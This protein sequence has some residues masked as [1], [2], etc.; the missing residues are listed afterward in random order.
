MPLRLRLRVRKIMPLLWLQLHEREMW[1]RLRIGHNL[2]FR[3]CT[4]QQKNTMK[5][6]ITRK[7]HS[8][9][10]DP[11]LSKLLQR[12]VNNMNKCCSVTIMQFRVMW[13]NLHKEKKNIKYGLLLTIWYYFLI[14]CEVYTVTHITQYKSGTVISKVGKHCEL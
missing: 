7:L 1:L 6:P 5:L 9:I 13:L 4:F 3:L 2:P 11:K 8:F 12:C 10:F 14:S